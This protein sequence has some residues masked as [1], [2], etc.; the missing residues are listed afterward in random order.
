MIVVFVWLSKILFHPT[1]GILN[2]TI[3][4]LLCHNKTKQAVSLD[5]HWHVTKRCT[6][7]HN[8]A[9]LFVILWYHMT[10]TERFK[11]GAM[12]ALRR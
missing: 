8:E 9:P 3:L 11:H 1:P 7:R 10:C 12:F 4:G 6:E 2:S 5:L